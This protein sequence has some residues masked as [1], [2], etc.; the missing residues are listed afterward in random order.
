MTQSQTIFYLKIAAV[1]G[2][3]AVSVFAVVKLTGKHAMCAGPPYIYATFHDEEA[4]VLKYSRN[5]CLLVDNV[6][7]DSDYHRKKHRTEL[8]SMAFGLYNGS[9]AL[10]VADARTAESYVLAYGSCEKDGRRP[11][12]STVV[13][14]QSNP[15]LNHVYG[16]CFDKHNNLYA[17]SQHTDNVLRFETNSFKEMNI[18]NQFDKLQHALRSYY[19]GTFVQFGQPG[20]HPDSEQGV[21][22]ICSVGSTIWIA[23]EEIHGISIADAVTGSVD[24]IINIPNPIGLHYDAHHHLVFVSS[25]LSK[26]R[27]SVYAI[28]PDTLT[29]VGNYKKKQNVASHWYHVLW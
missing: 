11:Y 9:K 20:V 13:S 1:V 22:S 7:G 16:L 5:G 21:R 27:G 6:L 8:R 17:S 24:N 3:V 28:D 10:F 18:P 4:N 2:F 26:K 19:P 12:L 29:V 15:G 25:K 23:N 14:S